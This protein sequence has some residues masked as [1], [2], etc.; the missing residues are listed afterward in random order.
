MVIGPRPPSSERQALYIAQRAD[1]DVLE[2]C[3]YPAL[4]FFALSAAAL[5]CCFCPPCR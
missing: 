4:G 1:E 2:A 5:T 3:V